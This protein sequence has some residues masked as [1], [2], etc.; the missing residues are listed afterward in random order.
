M[1]QFWTSSVSG[2]D[3][4]WWDINNSTT[5][6]QGYTELYKSFQS[7]KSECPIIRY[8]DCVHARSTCR[9]INW[10]HIPVTTAIC[11]VL[12]LIAIQTTGNT[13]LGYSFLCYIIQL[14][15]SGYPCKI[16][17]ADIV[18]RCK[19]ADV[20][21]FLPPSQKTEYKETI[22]FCPKYGQV[23]IFFIIDFWIPDICCIRKFLVRPFIIT[24]QKVVVDSTCY[25]IG[26]VYAASALERENQGTSKISPHHVEWDS[27]TTC[28]K[29]RVRLCCSFS[30]RQHKR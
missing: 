20:V 3:S 10:F 30:N 2:D 13:T 14:T 9:N 16:N 26:R 18:L 24:K 28:K 19:R 15:K 8:L 22:K 17:V 11:F 6:R 1:R 5:T 27:T 23:P 12:I 21:W 25:R 4:L 29:K 7:C